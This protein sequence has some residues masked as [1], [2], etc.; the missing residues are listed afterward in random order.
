LAQDM[1]WAP[2]YQVEPPDQSTGLKDR[3]NTEDNRKARVWEARGV[4]FGWTGVR[5]LGLSLGI[6]MLVSRSQHP[7][8]Q[9]T[10]S[11]GVILTVI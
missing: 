9:E 10:R 6:L 1:L 7:L 2:A 4:I 5:K 11:R 8:P 3:T